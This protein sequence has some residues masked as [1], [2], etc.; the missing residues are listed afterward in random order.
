[1]SAADVCQVILRRLEPCEEATFGGPMDTSVG[2]VVYAHSSVVDKLHYAGRE[3][4]RNFCFRRS[5][6]RQGFSLVLRIWLAVGGGVD[7]SR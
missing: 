6:R 7:E 5:K 1:M 4:S 3:P 2:A